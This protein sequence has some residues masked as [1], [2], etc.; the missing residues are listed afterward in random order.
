M[1]NSNSNN[2]VCTILIFLIQTMENN[3]TLIPTIS[4]HPGQIN[5]YNEVVWDHHKPIRDKTLSLNFQSTHGA[6]HLLNST[7]SARGRVS[8][9]AKRKMTRAVDYLLFVTNDKKVHNKYTGKNFKF[10]IAFVTLTLPSKQIHSDNEIKSKCLNQLLIELK[11]YYNVRN[12][13]WRAEKQHNGNLHFHILVDRFIPHQELRDRWNRI[14]N[15][16]GYVD[17]YRDEQIQWHNNGFRVRQNLLKT[18]PKRKQYDAYKRGSRIN[19]NSP[20]STDIH[21]TRNIKD[22]KGYVTK[23]FTKSAIEEFKIK[24][25]KLK[26]FRKS[27]DYVKPIIPG[28]KKRELI[29]C[30]RKR[31]SSIKKMSQKGRIWGCN[32]E[33]SN[34]KGAQSVLDWQIADELEKLVLDSSVRVLKDRYFQIVFLDS[35]YFARNPDSYLSKLFFDFLYDKFHYSLQTEFAA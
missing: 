23:Y 7:R 9:I 24:I 10:K 31:Q 13:I 26:E 12:Y 21:S 32:V 34:I 6:E 17:R 4:I 35:S 16:L 22:L 18:W 33:L 2:T 20:N 8:V 28:T 14:V 1:Q 11:K 5:I 15:K 19:W 29:K 3:L 27:P 30:K 25:S